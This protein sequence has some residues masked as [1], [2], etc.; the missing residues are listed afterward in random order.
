MKIQPLILNYMTLGM[1]GVEENCP[2]EQYPHRSG[3]GPLAPGHCWG[4]MV[5]V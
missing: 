3:K 2:P 5:V 4:M 1:L